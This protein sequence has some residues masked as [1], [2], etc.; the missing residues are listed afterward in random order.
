MDLPVLSVSLLQ[1]KESPD[2]VLRTE[3]QHHTDDDYY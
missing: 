3:Q 1:A 2:M